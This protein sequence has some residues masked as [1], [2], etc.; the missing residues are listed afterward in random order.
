M[1]LSALREGREFVPPTSP[2][3]SDDNDEDL[4]ELSD[5]EAIFEKIRPRIEEPVQEE[6]MEGLPDALE[7][8]LSS[9]SPGSEQNGDQQTL[10]DGL[11]VIS[12]D[13]GDEHQ[14]HRSIKQKSSRI[15]S[16]SSN[17]Q[18]DT[19][20]PAM[21]NEDFNQDQLWASDED[22]EPTTQFKNEDVDMEDLTAESTQQQIKSP[23]S[24]NS[25]SHVSESP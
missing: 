4:D 11:G 20:A 5:I 24:N 6:G 8:P 13:S 1:K 21:T 14:S 2:A 16:N 19:N 3:F 7:S 15:P 18:S 9:P 25:N 22:G 10:P 23:P 17:S 12:S